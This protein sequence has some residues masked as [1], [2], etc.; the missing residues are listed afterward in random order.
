MPGSTGA[1]SLM[2]GADDDA[3]AEAEKKLEGAAEAL[4]QAEDL[5]NDG[6]DLIMVAMDGTRRDGADRF[7]AWQ[8]EET[9]KLFTRVHSDVQAALAAV[10]G[11]LIARSRMVLAESAPVAPPP[12]RNARLPASV[13]P[14][15]PPAA[16]PARPTSAAPSTAGSSTA[17][18]STV[19]P[20]FSAG[21]REPV[22]ENPHG[23]RYPPQAGGSAAQL[24]PRVVPRSGDR[25]HGVMTINGRQV[26]ELNSGT[27]NNPELVRKASGMLRGL[28]YRDAEIR[29]LHHHVEV[30]AVQL[31]TQFPNADHGEVTINNTP[32]GVETFQ[33][34]V[35]VCDKQLDRILEA[36]GKSLTVYGTR[37][38][39]T[40][41]TKT[42]G[43]R[44]KE[45]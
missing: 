42:Y 10:R 30:K 13:A 45:S 44:R 8:A 26:A 39:N 4:H 29:Y 18:S 33:D 15:R 28:G 31:L 24:R 27:R 37:Q 41:F 9:G 19:V 32:C 11:M 38:D 40:P 1:G 17:G 2:T 34:S 20:G 25:T 21:E 43:K 23:D 7:D 36:F 16:A 3:L 14:W 22:Y 6:V 35:I 5:W 12:L